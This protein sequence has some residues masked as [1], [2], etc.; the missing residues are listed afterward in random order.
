MDDGS[1]NFDGSN[2]FDGPNILDDHSRA[3]RALSFMDRGHHTPEPSV[4][5][6]LGATQ[7]TIPVHREESDSKPRAFSSTHP[8]Q[9]DGSNDPTDDA[10]EGAPPPA[11]VWDL[12]QAEGASLLSSL[13]PE[14]LTSPLSLAIIVATLITTST[15]APR[16]V[17]W[18]KSFSNSIP[19]F[20]EQMKDKY[21]EIYNEMANVPSLAG[22]AARTAFVVAYEHIN[23]VFGGPGGAKEIFLVAIA[24]WILLSAKSN[25]SSYLNMVLRMYLWVPTIGLD[26]L[27]DAVTNASQWSRLLSSSATWHSFDVYTSPGIHRLDPA[28]NASS[29]TTAVSCIRAWHDLVSILISAISCTAD[30]PELSALR[31]QLKPGDASHVQRDDEPIVEYLSR[32]QLAFNQTCADLR[33]LGKGAELPHPNV[34][35]VDIV[36]AGARELIL[37]TCDRLLREDG[38]VAADITWTLFQE[39]LIR[40]GPIVD[41]QPFRPPRRRNPKEYPKEKEKEKAKDKDSKQPP[42]TAPIQG[43]PP[44]AAAK[45][46]SKT[47]RYDKSKADGTCSNCLLKHRL[48]DCP[49][50]R[51]DGQPWHLPHNFGVAAPGTGVSS[52]PADPPAV[53]RSGVVMT[54]SSIGLSEEAPAM[55]C[56]AVIRSP[57]RTHTDFYGNTFTTGR[58]CS[59]SDS[60]ES[61]LGD[62]V[63]PSWIDPAFVTPKRPDGTSP[64]VSVEYSPSPVHSVERPHATRD[65]PSVEPPV[66]R[67]SP[68]DITDAFHHAS[69]PA[70][71]PRL[72]GRVRP[73]DGH[74]IGTASSTTTWFA[75]GTTRSPTTWFTAGTASSPTTWFNSGTA[76]SP[77]TSLLWLPFVWLYSVLTALVVFT[78]HALTP[79]WRARGRT[80][81]FD[82]Y[83]DAEGNV[84]PHASLAARYGTTTAF[85]LSRILYM[86]P[87][88]RGGYRVT[89]AVV[90]MIL[91][92][93]LTVPAEALAATHNVSDALNSASSSVGCPGPATSGNVGVFNGFLPSGSRLTIGPDTFCDVSMIDPAK[94]D[95]TW[96]SRKVTSPMW[97]NGIGGTAALDTVVLVPVRLQWGAPV[98]TLLMYVGATPPGVDVIMGR[99]VLNALGGIVDCTADRFFVAAHKLDIPIDSIASNRARVDAPPMTVMATSSGCSLA[100]CTMRNLGFTISKWYAV[101]NDELCRKVASTIV[102][103]A[104]LHHIEPHD[105]TQLPQWVNTLHVD[106]HLD[107]SPCQ[108]FSRARR[109]P[110]G[111]RDT[112]RTAPAR[113]AAALFRRLRQ[114]NPNICH[115]VENVQFH[116]A[117]QADKAQFEALWTSTF[118]PLNASDY[119]SPSSRPR[120]YLANFTD[121]SKLPKRPSL[122]PHLVLDPGHHPP[123]PVLPCV[124]TIPDTHNPPCSIPPGSKTPTLVSIEVMER[125]QGWPTGI[126]DIGSSSPPSRA[127]RQRLIGNALNASQLWSILRC[128]PTAPS[129]VAR[130]G[131]TT[132]P[133]PPTA[134]QLEH[135]L[136]AMSQHKLDE[137]VLA[138]KGD[139]TPIPLHLEPIP[140]QLPPAKPRFNYSIPAGLRKSCNYA[141]DLEIAKGHMRELKPDEYTS[142]MFV[143]PG[144]VQ[145]KPGRFYEGTDIQ[146]V[147]L[148]S[149]S[150]YLNAAMQPSPAHHMAQCP[151][152]AD[153][154][155]RVPATARYF[156]TYDITDAFHSCKVADASLQYTV[157]QFGDRMVQYTGGVQGIANMAIHWNCHL[158]DILDRILGIHWREFYT[159]YVDDV[160]VHGAT[161]EQVITRSRVLEAILRAFGKTINSKNSSIPYDDHMDLAG[162][163]F[164]SRGVSLSDK[165]I[166]SLHDALDRYPV[167]TQTD[168]Q[169]VVGVI[170]YSSSAFSWPDALPSPE[171]VDLVSA[172]NGIGLAPRKEI[173]DRWAA[174]FPA[175]HAR[176][177]S[178]LHNLPRA[179]LDPATL[180]SPDTCLVQVTDA[181]DTGVAVSLFRVHRSDASTVTKEDLLNPTLSQLIAVRYRKL[182]DTQRRWHTFESELYAMVLGVKWYG[183][184]IT[185]ATANFPSS[186]TPKIAFWSDSTTALSQWTS[187][188]LPASTTDFLSAKARRFHAWADEVSYTKYWPLFIRH[189]PGETNDLA[190]VMS[191]LGDQ[192]HTRAEYLSSVGAT[193][194]WAP[195]V[196]FPGTHSY[197]ADQPRDPL[198]DFTMVH[199]PLSAAQVD[200][201]AEAYLSD[202]SLVAKV[203]LSDVYRVVTDHPT[204]VS[205]PNMHHQS[206]RGWRNT[207]FF[208]VTPPG[209]A[210]PILYTP[211]TATRIHDCEAPNSDGTRVLVPVIPRGADV[212]ITTNPPIT[213]AGDGTHYQDHDLRRDLL[214]HCHDNAHHA[215]LERTHTNL[216]AIAWWPLMSADVTTHWETC[217]YCLAARTARATVGDAV[218]AVH[219]FRLVE[220]DHKILDAEV[221]AATGCD[222][223]LTMVDDVS[224]LTLFVPVESTSTLHAAHAIVTRWY[225]FFGVPMIFRSD[226]GSAFTSDL[227]LMVCQILG[228]NGWDLSAPDNPTHHSV[229]ERRNRVMEHFL[230]VGASSGDLTSFEA[231]ELYA[232][233]ATATCNLEYEYNGHT[234]MEYVT[235]A[236]PR[237]HN[238][239]VIKPVIDDVPTTELD[240]AFINS[241]RA[242]INARTHA[243]KILRDDRARDN[244]LRKSAT[245]A[246]AR[247]T[248]FDLRPGD[249][250]SYDAKR[251]V[252][253]RHTRSTPTA[254]MRSEIRLED[255]PA[256]APIEVLYSKLRPLATHRPQ[257][258]LSVSPGTQVPLA[259]GDFIFYSHPTTR[260]VNA[261]VVIA[262]ETSRCLVHEHR[263]APKAERLFTPLYYDADKD[264]Y[265][266]KVKPTS[267][268]EAVVV[269][270]SLDDVI[271]AGSISATRYI[272]SDLLARLASLGITSECARLTQAQTA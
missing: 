44:P 138:R 159:I 12:A 173:A 69:P 124:V 64:T 52:P 60:E 20:V 39:Y 163:H 108:P 110:P 230:D 125:L 226:K 165:A 241:L 166:D 31:A 67:F 47:E 35:L 121:L 122:A 184:F 221:A 98:D 112:V 90:L 43:R 260:S 93:W 92:S 117:L 210:R 251:F 225:P 10:A 242:V 83:A 188:T 197:H 191:H 220:I 123:A 206:I 148:L 261:G 86:L 99:D 185:T 238:D 8:P 167:K 271:T 56:P 51:C 235:G 196:A 101:D 147:R 140:G 175:I 16:Y 162:L 189:I 133:I 171:F 239:L 263:Q 270:V 120:Q 113:C 129:A 227:M 40:A 208:S 182:T 6:R 130:P 212:R 26:L 66:E 127:D 205:V 264:T 157:V 9:R 85:F 179:A 134:S 258:M 74:H 33:A 211:S 118:V 107:T 105:V 234:V 48:R 183:S 106:L 142:A 272:D 89:M 59:D 178:L 103:A 153:M 247:T 198:A 42:A 224:K 269:T 145:P 243:A 32:M 216:K 156:R 109:N 136:G 229:V 252:L 268:M 29:T 55:G 161:P 203:P 119:G 245:T 193:A 104:E 151:T 246:Q 152:Q 81:Y 27:R 114:T 111:F 73:V 141:I 21:P 219:R 194:A 80:L 149:D 1:S 222:A 204:K 3:R 265:V 38:K 76:R 57:P 72:M 88:P 7:G 158:H 50:D 174:E 266:Q 150:R 82:D 63:D 37:K 79:F 253:L 200:A 168:V 144:F 68:I 41:A 34:A 22:S 254:P 87:R 192:L 78:D 17:K 223:I 13:G 115:L 2:N 172:L 195:M 233:A 24:V 11:D 255:D 128:L 70:T 62:D 249:V 169:H 240:A 135:Q 215:T 102:P 248:S 214:L 180:L 84:Y 65:M 132:P 75:A 18:D 25:K 213:D 181:S 257:H 259:T 49:Y 154:C 209:A 58:L 53:G 190:H 15:F 170:Q 237:T 217:A 137:W 94:V 201:I 116:R 218:H 46:M 5:S 186:G 54:F 160:G 207:R 36:S 244:A 91:L 267:S 187:L 19:G 97:L 139:Y 61:T 28:L 77:T 202:T 155:Y 131:V 232:A 256:A 176:L 199:L 30:G 262:L 95:P 164:D 143:S 4:S 126:T 231:L 250:V 177:K 14:R 45:A 236:Q 100:Y 96:P 228:V 71:L 146:M 23:A